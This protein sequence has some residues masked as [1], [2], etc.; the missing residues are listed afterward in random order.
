MFDYNRKLNPKQK[1]FTKAQFD[2]LVA[3]YKANESCEE[4]VDFEPVV[5]LFGGAA[6]TWLLTELDPETG[7]AFGLCDLGM[8]SPEVGC[9][10]IDE[11]MGIKFPPFGL[12]AERD[13][14]F[15]AKKPLSEYAED[16]RNRG[17]IR[18]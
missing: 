6:C 13:L 17:M 8:G 16:A 2:Q 15:E 7:I 18:A 11:I 5:K 10:S 3:N 1:V 12:P 4:P 14:W 9:V